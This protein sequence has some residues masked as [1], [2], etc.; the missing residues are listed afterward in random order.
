MKLV[1]SILCTILIINGLLYVIVPE[2]ARDNLDRV[3]VEII[4]PRSAESRPTSLRDPHTDHNHPPSEEKPGSRFGL[5]PSRQLEAR[6]WMVNIS[7]PEIQEAVFVAFI[8]LF[9]DD[10]SKRNGPLA[11]EKLDFILQKDPQNAVA[12]RLLG[13]YHID[14]GFRI[15]EA[16]ENYRKAIEIAPDYGDAHYALAFTLVT[17]DL[18]LAEKHFVRALELGVEDE[19]ELAK[20][21][22]KGVNVSEIQ[23][24]LPP[25]EKGPT[26]IETHGSNGHNQ[27]P[28][29]SQDQHIHYNPTES[30]SASRLQEYKERIEVVSDAELNHALSDAYIAVFHENKAKR[31]GPFAKERLDWV[32][33]QDPNSAVAYRILGYYHIDHGFRL[34]DAITCYLKALELDAN[35]GDVH[36]ALAFSMAMSNPQEAEKYFIRALELGVEDERNLAQKFFKNVNVSEIQ[37]KK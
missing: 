8:S 1:L 9:H 2:G 7:V 16:L 14:N 26:A 22:F 31:N 28:T 23:K 15:D 37:K 11:K 25:R 4:P 6:Q 3:F 35:Y 19:R 5:S 36:Y 33:Q 20:K 13:Y 17:S 30:L 21:Y 24:N 29:S 34:K 27:T 32:L 10:K 12:Y 18:K